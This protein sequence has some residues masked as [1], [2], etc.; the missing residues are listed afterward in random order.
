MNNL[1]KSYFM[2]IAKLTGKLSTCASKQVGAVLVFNN[3]IIGIAYNGV[4]SKQEHCNKIFS[5]ET[6]AKDRELHHLWSNKNEL[7]AEQNLISYCARNGI[8]TEDSILFLTISPCIHCAKIILVS[9]IKEVYYFEEYDKDK[10][11]IDFL[12]K[13][14]V[15]CEKYVMPFL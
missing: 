9:G 14:D 4:P 7:H 1:K 5:K 2:E 15:K 8:K 3:R 13:N 11:G 6:I 10:T 12:I